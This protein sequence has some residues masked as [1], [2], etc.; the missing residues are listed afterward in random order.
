VS[1]S[2]PFLFNLQKNKEEGTTQHL[3][4]PKAIVQ[5]ALWLDV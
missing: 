5:A 2:I 3:Y 1:Q 4:L